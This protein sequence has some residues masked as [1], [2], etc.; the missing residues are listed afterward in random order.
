LHNEIRSNFFTMSSGERETMSTE[1]SDQDQLDPFQVITELA[2][3]NPRYDREAYLFVIQGL[4]WSMEQLGQRRHL[5]GGELAEFLAA[6]AREEFGAMA[7][8]VLN[9]WGIFSTRDF[10]EIVYRLIDTGLMSKQEGDTIDDFD[11]VLDLEEALN[12]P[13]FSP[14][15][16]E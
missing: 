2:I 11:E 1:Y 12:N 8:F 9:E 6:Y 4:E 15:P 7:L 10:G 5:S 14:G 13:N 3:E 16:L